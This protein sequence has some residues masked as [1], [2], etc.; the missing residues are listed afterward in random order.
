[1]VPNAVTSTGCA[2]RTGW[3]WQRSVM[4]D[5]VPKGLPPQLSRAGQPPLAPSP[6]PHAASAP[7]PNANSAL[8]P[9]SILE[10][11]PPGGLGAVIPRGCPVTEGLRHRLVGD[12]HLERR[13][14]RPPERPVDV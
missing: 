6:Q 5:Q 13:R 3:N 11:K 7:R 12:R 2:G 9:P 8:M 14:D 1:M 4:T 10:E